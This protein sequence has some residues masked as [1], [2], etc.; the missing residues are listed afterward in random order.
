M[1]ISALTGQFLPWPGRGIL[2]HTGRMGFGRLLRVGTHRGDPAAM[3]YVVAEPEAE[4]AAA[5]LKHNLHLPDN[6]DI[7]DLGRVTDTLLST[8]ELKQ[9]DYSKT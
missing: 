9:G 3:V 6:T 4:K 2:C 7:E 8:L 5:I 1:S